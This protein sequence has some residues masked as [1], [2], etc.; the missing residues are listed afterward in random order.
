MN[1]LPKTLL[2]LPMLAIF[3]ISPVFAQ[4]LA[5]NMPASAIASATATGEFEFDE[6][7][8]TFSVNNEG[9]DVADLAAK[10]AKKGTALVEAMKASGLT[11]ADLR[12]TGPAISVKYAT[13]RNANGPE[14]IDRQ[15][16]DGYSGFLSVTARFKDFS[17]IGKA[18]SDGMKLGAAASGPNY[19]LSPATSDEKLAGLATESTKQALANAKAMIEATGRKAGR[20]LEIRAD[21]GAQPM[22]DAPLRAMAMAAPAA[23]IQVPV[24]PGRATLSKSVTV[25]LEILEP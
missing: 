11:D 1:W 9:Q 20:V 4:N 14:I 25:T 17:K 7:H 19:A 18:I 10:L 24:N 2:P 5:S 23:D 8:L 12:V 3:A 6:V 15:R 22:F 16:I 13:I 21:G